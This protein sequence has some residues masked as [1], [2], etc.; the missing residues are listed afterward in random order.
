[1]KRDSLKHSDSMWLFDVLQQSKSLAHRYQLLYEK[2]EKDLLPFVNLPNYTDHGLKHALNLQ[3]ILARLVSPG[4]HEP[5]GPFEVFVLLAATLLH[6]VGMLV[7]KRE[8]EGAELVRLDHAHRSRDFIIKMRRALQFTEHEAKII[9][10]VCRAHGMETLDYLTGS[11]FSL[12]PHGEVRVQLLSG[13][14]RLADAL[15]V[16]SERAPLEVAD[17]RH[18]PAASR[19][20]WEIHRWISDVQIHSA[21]WR[22]EI[23]AMPDEKVAESPFYELRSD[24]QREL[25]TISA[26]L[27]GAGIFYQHIDLHVNRDAGRSKIRRR[28]NPFLWLA[29]FGS[30]HAYLFAGRDTEKQQLMERIVDRRLVVLIGESGVGKTSLVEA[31]IRPQLKDHKLGMVTF[32]F[33]RDPI[34]SLNQSLSGKLRDHKP[35]EDTVA[36]IRGYLKRRR[37]LRGVLLIG[38]HLEQMF[39]LEQSSAVR[40][41]FVKE[42][43]R[44]LSADIPATLLFCIREDYLPDLYSLSLD[45]PELYNRD[46]T[47]RLHRLS[48]ERALEV[49]ER[50]SMHARVAMPETLQRKIAQE[51]CY[52]GGGTVYPPFLQI[53]GGRL[54]AALKARDQDTRL[55]H[56]R[57]ETLYEQFGRSEQIVNRYFEGLLDKYSHSDKPMVQRLLTSMVTDYYTKKRVRLEDLRR[58]LPDCKNLTSLLRRLVNQRVLRRSLGE[59]ELIHDFLARK[60]IEFIKTKSF[61][62]PRVRAAMAFVDRKLADTSLTCKDIAGAAK[63]SPSH[64]TVLFRAE[65]DMTTQQYLTYARILKAKTLLGESRERIGTVAHWVGFRN[66]SSFTTAFKRLEGMT[67]MQ[68]R[69]LVGYRK[70]GGALKPSLTATETGSV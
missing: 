54:Y 27:R 45:L 15:D 19:A 65:L 56:Y 41:R 9:G 6:D 22:I 43:S 18:I 17:G 11:T 31:G 1:M 53:V 4:L 69:K 68:H 37:K 63:V 64:L 36:N 30:T 61:V 70:K 50:A 52:E 13:L 62:S 28:S 26:I 29:P 10:E 8:K 59:Y 35:S 60:V 66:L 55:A 2:A 49:L 33:Q 48:K 51:L 67:P 5:L 38:D 7:S 44:I 21:N 39:T 12:S 32:S 23:I 40:S 3:N 58:E 42:V 24:I 57:L 16:T 20:H 14:L 47:L 46:N 34:Q 25:N